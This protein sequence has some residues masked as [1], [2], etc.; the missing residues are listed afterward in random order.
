MTNNANHFQV[1][2]SGRLTG[3]FKYHPNNNFVCISVAH[4]SVRGEH[5]LTSNNI[6]K[7]QKAWQKKYTNVSE[8][9]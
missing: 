2:S 7:I 3:L 4:V 6:N 1:E 8:D 5:D 9:L